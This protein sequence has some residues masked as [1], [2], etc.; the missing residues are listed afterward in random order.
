M[1]TRGTGEEQALEL[2][3]YDGA[4][5]LI[6][7]F[8][9]SEAEHTSYF[10]AV[11]LDSEDRIWAERTPRDFSENRVWSTPLGG[12]STEEVATPAELQMGAPGRGGDV[13]FG[14]LD[15]VVAYSSDLSRSWARDL[16]GGG[17]LVDN[18]AV[19]PDDSVVVALEPDLQQDNEGQHAATL[20]RILDPA[21]NTV[22]ELDTDEAHRGLL[23]HGA[24]HL[25][26]DSTGAIV[27]AYDESRAADPD[28]VQARV[29]VAKYQPEGT[30]SWRHV[31]PNS[32][33][34]GSTIGVCDLSVAPDDTV[35][36]A[37]RRGYNNEQP[38]TA[39]VYRFAP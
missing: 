38:S 27:F 34:Y 35:L 30:L 3:Q 8:E 9:P 17:K 20:I 28:D 24:S 12:G 21:G 7:S 13:V 18:I 31:M 33:I 26:V 19:G 6:W 11:V 29:I 1:Y 22:R 2:Q 32:E 23:A 10:E 15:F 16:A 5:N 4:A 37:V 36:L 14:G 39:T 25:A